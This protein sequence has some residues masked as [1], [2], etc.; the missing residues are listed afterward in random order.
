MGR[1]YDRQRVVAKKTRTPPTP[2]RPVQAPKRR[3][4]PHT[5]PTLDLRRRRQIL[6]GVAA[7]GIAGLVAVVLAILIPGGASAKDVAKTLA[8]A[9]CTLKSMPPLPPTHPKDPSG[10][11]ADVPTL[12]TKV[13]WST[14][15]PSAGGHYPLWAIWGFYTQPVNPRQVVHNEEHGGVV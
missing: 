6:Y 14:F 12:T 4:T 5:R 8:A 13:K 7:A 3:E 10:Y 15:P 11:H 2:R 9:G 1:C